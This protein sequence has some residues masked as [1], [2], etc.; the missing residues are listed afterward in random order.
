MTDQRTPDSKQTNDIAETLSCGHSW[1]G[2]I[3]LRRWL[4][5]LN[6]Q[7][8]NETKKKA[9]KAAFLF[10]LIADQTIL[11][12]WQMPLSWA[13]VL[14]PPRRAFLQSACSAV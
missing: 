8:E 4:A 5:W 6:A 13:L 14:V 12:C 1:I 10:V 3:I 7:N 11:L 2:N 9:A